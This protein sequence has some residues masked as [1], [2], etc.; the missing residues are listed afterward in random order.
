MKKMVLT[1]KNMFKKN[2]IVVFLYEFFVNRI[3][4]AIS[5][6][7]WE[8]HRLKLF[9]TVKRHYCF[10]TKNEDRVFYLISWRE[11]KHGIYSMILYLLP[12][13]IYAVGKSYIPVIDL[14]N[15]YMPL[16]QDKD[17]EGKENAW[18]YYFEQ[19]FAFYSIDDVYQSRHVVLKVDEL[20]RIKQ[21]DWREIF[22]TDN[23]ILKYWGSMFRS[24][25]RLQPSL[26]I[27][28]EETAKALLGDRE[29][30]GISVRAGYL[31]GM[32]RNSELYNGHRRQPLY[33]EFIKIIER[34]L[35]EWSYDAFFLACDD[36]E[37]HDGIKNYFGE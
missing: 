21:P 29:I 36:R 15:S 26:R 14:K 1:I 5:K 2:F 10:G 6:S 30:V 13:I 4:W 22:P 32:M 16:L 23:D 3:K 18:E 19:P 37:Y 11:K 20:H 33:E 24:Y 17:K 34:K 35:Q 7:K 9:L 27:R 25:I 31:A 28:V 12:H 8:I